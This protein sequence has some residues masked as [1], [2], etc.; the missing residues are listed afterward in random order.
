MH[1]MCDLTIA[2]ESAVFRQVGPIMGSVDAGFGTWALEDLL[3]AGAPR[4]CGS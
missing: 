4:R 2:A 1:M 3:G